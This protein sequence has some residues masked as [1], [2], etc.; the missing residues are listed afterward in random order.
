MTEE[1]EQE[2]KN[3]RIRPQERA[4]GQKSLQPHCKM[5]MQNEPSHY[6]KIDCVPKMSFVY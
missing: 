4:L 2:D 6:L 3:K 1:E 5:A